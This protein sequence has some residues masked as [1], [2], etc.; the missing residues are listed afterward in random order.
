MKYLILTLIA[1]FILSGLRHHVVESRVY[2]TDELTGKTTLH[3]ETVHLKELSFDL[4]TLSKAGTLNLKSEAYETLL[5]VK[6]GELEISGNS[7]TST[8]GPGSVALIL[9]G[10]IFALKANVGEVSFY[11][12]EY[13]SKKPM[14]LERGKE[15]G[16][17]FVIDFDELEFN[18]HGRGG[19]RNYFNRSTAMMEYFEMHVTNL[20]GLI[21]SH[22][23]HTHG[24]AEIVL[25]IKGNTEMEIGDGFYQGTVGDVYFLGSDV[26]HAIENKDAEQCMYFAFQWE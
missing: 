15:A 23:P 1:G 5:I 18:P 25:M 11:K 19:I 17:S 2:T 20:N 6:E 4:N 9:P 22:E 14:D 16:G 8:V 24:T 3:G 21:K 7:K 13:I 10:D 26:P 12:M